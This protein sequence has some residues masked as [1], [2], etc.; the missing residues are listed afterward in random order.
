MQD[1]WAWN[2]VAEVSARAAL[3]H[4]GSPMPARR[5]ARTSASSLVRAQEAA[6]ARLLP[7]AA[8]AASDNVGSGVFYTTVGSLRRRVGA[9][10]ETARNLGDSVA[11]FAGAGARRKWRATNV[12]R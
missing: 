8:F 5:L 4:R 7:G 9:G 3:L 10:C 12:V 1:D 11:P 2:A 6:P